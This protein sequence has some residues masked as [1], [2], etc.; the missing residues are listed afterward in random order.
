MQIKA[1]DLIKE[2]K[3]SHKKVKFIEKM[4]PPKTIYDAWCSFDNEAIRS[5]VLMQKLENN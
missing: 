2:N 1:R 4:D 3:V 5:N